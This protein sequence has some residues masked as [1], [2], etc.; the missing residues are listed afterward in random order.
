M[1]G[2][3]GVLHLLEM[4]GC[5]QLVDEVFTECK[6][7]FFVGDF[8]F[9]NVGRGDTEKIVVGGIDL[10]SCSCLIILPDMHQEHMHVEQF[11]LLHAIT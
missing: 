11:F 5:P 10:L 7:G 9:M 4:W 3:V 1:G 2:F 6:N 8:V